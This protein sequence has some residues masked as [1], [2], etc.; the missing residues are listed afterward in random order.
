MDDAS[1]APNEDDGEDGEN[2]K[3][4]KAPSVFAKCSQVCTKVSEF[5][6]GIVF[7]EITV[8]LYTILGGGIALAGNLVP[9]D[10]NI[11]TGAASEVIMFLFIVMASESAML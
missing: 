9:P 4:H 11:F 3:H 5:I 1:A 8:G 10:Y 6:H 2:K 7:H